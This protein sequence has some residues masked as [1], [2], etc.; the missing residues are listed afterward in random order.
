MVTLYDTGDLY[1]PYAYDQ[2]HEADYMAWLYSL[3]DNDML[4]ELS[5][6]TDTNWMATTGVDY[7]NG[8]LARTYTIPV[9]LEYLC[10]YDEV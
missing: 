2:D 10:S 5:S 1:N 6:W 3:S 4:M 7:L 9:P 8:I